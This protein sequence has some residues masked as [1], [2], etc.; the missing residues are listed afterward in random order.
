[1]LVAMVMIGETLNYTAPMP[2][3]CRFAANVDPG[4]LESTV[5]ILRG[6]KREPIPIQRRDV[7][8]QRPRDRSP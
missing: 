3:G 4:D 1:M 6:M 8:K 2:F 7:M 5:Q